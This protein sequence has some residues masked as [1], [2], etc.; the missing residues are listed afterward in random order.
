VTLALLGGIVAYS[1]AAGDRFVQA[2]LGVGAAGWA[3][4][5]AALIGRWPSVLPWGFVG[6]AASYTVYLSLRH[7]TAD[8]RAPFVAAAL[9]VAAELG[10]WSV[11]R[12]A[13]RNERA[14]VVRR[15]AVIA[16]GTLGTALLGSLLLVVAASVSGG[17]GLEA[18]GV[19]A[20]VGVLATVAVLAARSRESSST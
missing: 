19:L 13:G 7:G 4:T 15:L 18:I 6:A 11:E 14:V 20:A 17:L 1:V 2:V 8:S 9:F 10:F 3:L 16:L 12:T 5:L